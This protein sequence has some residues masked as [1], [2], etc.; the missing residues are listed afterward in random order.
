MTKTVVLD[1]CAQHEVS[2]TGPEA[3]G[4]RLLPEF[5]QYWLIQTSPWSYAPSVLSCQFKQ[6][7]QR[8]ISIQQRMERW[9]QVNTMLCLYSSV[10]TNASS[11]PPVRLEH[12]LDVS[13]QG[14]SGFQVMMRL[15]QKSFSPKKNKVRVSKWIRLK[16]RRQFRLHCEKNR[17]SQIFLHSKQYLSYSALSV[18]VPF[19]ISRLYWRKKLQSPT[20]SSD[21]R[22]V[23]QFLV[24][25]PRWKC[26]IERESN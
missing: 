4:P 20:F 15:D 25:F 1:H 11:D 9:S 8:A 6:C 24:A 26:F 17:A 7:R 21:L 12:R 23:N 22:L 14:R 19:L 16:A 3:L 5:C 10:F 18:N 13:E 2:Q